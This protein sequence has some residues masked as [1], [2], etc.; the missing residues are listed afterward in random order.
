MTPETLFSR[1]N[2]A[3]DDGATP[4]SLVK[5]AVLQASP[6][7]HREA[8]LAFGSWEAYIAA[9]VV[10]LRR[11]S[12]GEKRT[13]D[14]SRPDEPRPER[15]AGP[16]GRGH[17][18]A[19]S[20]E[21]YAFVLS[22]ADV[23]ATWERALYSLDAP[24]NHQIARIDAAEDDTAVVLITT[25]GN[26]LAIDLRLLPE[27][28]SDALVRPLTLRFSGMDSR[29]RITCAF[30]KRSLRTGNRVYFVSEQGQVKASDASEYR[31]L[32]SEAMA[33][34]LLRED[35]ALLTAFAAPAE[36]RITLWSSLAKA[37]VFEAEE[38]RS[39]GRKA[40]GVKGIGLDEG[41]SVVSAFVGDDEGMIVLSTRQ[42]FFKRMRMADFRPQGRA[43]GGLQTC[44]LVAGDE[45][46]SVCQVDLAGDIAVITTTGRVARFPAYEVPLQGRAARGDQLLELEE[47]EHVLRV[48]GVAA[49]ECV[50][51]PPDFETEIETGIEAAEGSEHAEMTDDHDDHDDD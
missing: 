14:D 16:A 35:D 45:V 38:L 39:Q 30:P 33:A 36:C 48:V 17:A 28:E 22:L 19:I 1:L 20:A 18:F 23:P 2:D 11:L 44:R 34:T 25:M 27:W 15:V 4:D 50:D 40:T 9:A 37:L 32:S 6:G 13:S 47:G 29:E 41:A 5:E 3:I 42:G 12:A 8:A 51:S 31:K 49:G 7:W 26:G 10:R 43:G 24:E 46:A 21:G